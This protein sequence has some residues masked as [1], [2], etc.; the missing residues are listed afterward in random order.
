VDQPLPDDTKRLL[1]KL[2]AES[3]AS[4]EVLD[5]YDAGGSPA[6]R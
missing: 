4:G 1:N 2:V 6:R 3:T 5:I